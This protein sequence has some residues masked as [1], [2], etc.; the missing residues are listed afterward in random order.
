VDLK[1]L[2][3][4]ARELD[5]LLRGGFV[6]KIHQPLPR[7]VV[8]RIRPPRGGEK[9][10]MLSADPRLGRLHLTDLKI[11]NPP[12]PPRFCA[13]LR[14]HF[15]GSRI[16]GVE[17]DADD[18]VVRIIGVRGPQEDRQHREIVLE[19]L[20]RDS[21][22]M[23]VDGESGVI[24]DCL[25]RIPEK[26]TGS[27]VVMPGTLYA[28]PPCGDRIVPSAT[29]AQEEQPPIPGIATTPNRAAHLSLAASGNEDRRFPSMNEAANAYFSD[30]L[31]TTLLEAQRRAVTAPVKAR[32]RSLQRRLDK[33]EGDRSRL[34]Q[35]KARG[36]EGELLKTN[37]GRVQKGMSSI[38]VQDW[39]TGEDRTIVLEP[40]LDAVANM[41]KLFKQAAK[42]KRGRSI[43][44]ERREQTEREIR[45]L[46]DHLYYLESAQD[47]QELEAV[48]GQ[49]DPVPAKPKR[50]TTEKRGKEKGSPSSLVREYNAPSSRVVLVGKSSQG[51]EFLLRQKADKEDLWFHV[52]DRP[53][54][55]V[56]LRKGGSGSIPEEDVA[57]AAGLAVHFS[58]ARG[59][60]KVE[61]IVAVAKDLDRPKGGSPGQVIVRHFRCVLAEG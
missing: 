5:E 49:A 7:E 22:I 34:E 33:I 3:V 46:Q 60:G 24:M 47:L 59:K 27:R 30:K 50:G 56:L 19:L 36:E 51:N 40:A 6:S 11:P 52:K 2:Q 57:F 23:L 21:N 45:S 26:D 54:A 14:A 37:L 12:V 9:K 61:V 25:H 55:H 58:S 35:F 38:V 39:L 20:G 1:I 43:V 4:V 17:A 16:V 41:Q 31:Q 10:L 53:G 44:E 15:Q 32:V 28:A 8:L 48:T 42:G 13:Y 18:R 29:D